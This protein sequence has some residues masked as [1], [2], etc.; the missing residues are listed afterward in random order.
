MLDV[1]LKKGVSVLL[2]ICMILTLIPVLAFAQDPANDL[3]TLTLQNYQTDFSGKN[4]F[5]GAPDPTLKNG[6]QEISIKKENFELKVKFKKYGEEAYGTEED[7]EVDAERFEHAGDYE[8]TVVGKQSGAYNGR[9]SNSV[10]FKINPQTVSPSSVELKNGISV[11]KVYDGTNKVNMGLNDKIPLENF[12]YAGKALYDVFVTGAKY[13]KADVGSDIAISGGR[14]EFK[15]VGDNDGAYQDDFIIHVP[16]IKGSITEKH[17][18]EDDILTDDMKVTKVF[19]GTVD[20]GN[21]VIQGTAYVKDTDNKVQAKGT[22][23]S[24]S[25]S[26]VGTTGTATVEFRE[27]LG[28]GMQ[29]CEF[30][31]S[32]TKTIPA[33]IV[34]AEITYPHSQRNFSQNEGGTF[35]AVTDHFSTNKAKGVGGVDISVTP[36]YYKD[37]AEQQ[38][39][40]VDAQRALPVGTHSVYVKLT[41]SDNNYN[42]LLLADP[43]RLTVN[44]LPSQDLEWENPD[45]LQNGVLNVT[46]GDSP[47]LKAQNNSAEGGAI[48]YRS[49]DPAVAEVDDQGLL[50]LKGPGTATIT[51]TAA[52]VPGKY[53]KTDLSY[54]LRVAKKPVKVKIKDVSRKYYFETEASDFGFW[55]LKMNDDPS[56]ANSHSGLEQGDEPADSV[57]IEIHPRADRYSDVGEYP[58]T[59]KF[60]YSQ[61][62]E[63]K[64]IDIIPGKLT[65][66]K[67]DSPFSGGLERVIK[68]AK[69]K[70][71]NVVF[72]IAPVLGVYRTE[73]QSIAIE[74]TQDSGQLIKGDVS[75]QGTNIVFA[76]NSKDSG[77]NAL[78][79]VTTK[80]KNYN[81]DKVK[82][83]VELAE[84]KTPNISGITLS[85]KVYDGKPASYSGSVLVDGRAIDNAVIKWFQGNSGTSEI[86]APLTPGNYKL[87]IEV[88]ATDE[89]ES[90]KIE[91][92]FEIHPRQMS[93]KVKDLSI[94]KGQTPS[95]SL[96]FLNLLEGEHI[97]LTGTTNGAFTAQYEIF[98]PDGMKADGASFQEGTYK[99]RLKNVSALAEN[100]GDN[101]QLGNNK[102]YSHD[103]LKVAEG[104]L[105]V[106]PAADPN[107]G[108][109]N[110][111]NQNHDFGSSSENADGGAAQTVEKSAVTTSSGMTTAVLTAESK[112]NG[113]EVSANVSDKGIEQAVALA[114]KAAKKENSAV[115]AVE[116]KLDTPK[117]AEAVKVELSKKAADV[118]AKSEIGSFSVDSA[119][120][121][122]SLDKKAIESVSKQSK[123]GVEVRVEKA[124][125]K[126]NDKQ[127]VAVGEAPVYD[128]TVKS[129][130]KQITS[131]DGGLVTVTLPY[132]LK[133]GELPNR[134]VIWYVDDMGNIQKVDSMY[135]VKTQRVM[136]TTDHLSKYVISYEEWMNVFKDVKESNWYYSAVKFVAERSLMSGT[137]GEMFSPNVP[138]T[139]AMLATVLY[140]TE[141]TPEL[142]REVTN[143]FAD[144]AEG[145][146]YTEAVKWAASVGIVKGMDART[147]APNAPLTREQ[148]AMMVYNYARYKGM[149]MEGEAVLSSFADHESVSKWA[150]PA[151]KW[152][153]GN[154][155]INGRTQTMLRPEG[156][157]TRAEIAKIL[158]ELLEK[159]K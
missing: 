84:K 152:A 17:V 149:K 127:K 91:L 13:D 22:V 135:D 65:I 52:M 33:E 120:A 20:P 61:K 46:Y 89:Y 151:V 156:K 133:K 11:S 32:V 105:T 59:G 78:I 44:A 74:S 100:I 90:G 104:T 55:I 102:N 150:I 60:L 40:N 35:A 49:S 106:R 30:S 5:K 42:P 36:T 134:V 29:N 159:M 101:G 146:Y 12:N 142:S 26:A 56:T 85:D 92:K 83:I 14:V 98:T 39:L 124:N 58:I 64:E 67:D 15:V 96:E 107:Q 34:K 136:F 10:V 54:T 147:F 123:G 70:E 99:V 158:M 145:A 103:N 140:R 115:S 130:G 77:T 62:Y 132:T 114:E 141:G 31:N 139:R 18:G 63:V 8:I 128:I 41:P 148:V 71:Q 48:S 88:P 37:A 131:F 86:S 112:V 126:L 79:T 19:D 75:V 111:G 50:T 154:R 43:I 68:I 93:A 121:A 117:N 23:T 38:E 138:T 24:F 81:D 155:I 28:E 137:S 76:T 51:A 95:F 57:A 16:E 125:S 2:S 7:I 25:S 109:Q 118:L 144:V 143:P 97:D 119:V 73:L 72:D 80:F 157:A 94:T 3:L 66:T 21:A 69:N 122:V 1:I 87:Q 27:L 108:N 4:T 9:K 110:Q 82:I 113:K 129:G 47:Y 6:D 116:I 53:G 45:A 153:H